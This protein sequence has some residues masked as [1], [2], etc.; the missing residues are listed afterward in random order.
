MY[1]TSVREMRSTIQRFREQEFQGA[2]GVL[3]A[4]VVLVKVA[5]IFFQNFFYYFY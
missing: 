2:G 5:I 3:G 1:M 4:R